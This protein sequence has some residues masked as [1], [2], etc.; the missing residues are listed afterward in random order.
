MS[1]TERDVHPAA[2]VFP[3]LPDDELRELAEDIKANGLIHPIVLDT[4]GRIV[5]GINRD[6]ACDMAGVE[7]Q[8]ITLPPETDI[9]GYILSQNVRRRHMSKGQQ[10]MA[11]AL[12]I[13]TEEGRRDGQANRLSLDSKLSKGDVSKAVTIRRYAADLAPGVLANTES[14]DGAYTVAVARKREQDG[15]RERKERQV[16]E[17]LIEIERIRRIA[18]DIADLVPQTLTVADAKLMLVQ[19]EQRERDARESMARV[20]AIACDFFDPGVR[21]TSDDLAERV[22][23]T[24]DSSALPTRPIFTA[25]RFARCAETAAAIARRLETREDTAHGHAAARR[26][27]A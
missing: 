5:D 8:Y 12:M 17:D 2:A 20:A 14:F 24:L 22:V 11:I 21:A 3:R 25:A 26:G 18:P 23:A 9:V 10:A 19:R 1:D 16:R 13:E 15:E 7:K 27:D 6:A 4:D